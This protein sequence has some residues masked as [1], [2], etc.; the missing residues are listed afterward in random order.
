MINTD[1]GHVFQILWDFVLQVIK[2]MSTLWDFLTSKQTIGFNIPRVDVPVVGS[3][4]NW[5]IDFLNDWSL[6]FVPI[7]V[8]VGGGLITLLTLYLIKTFVPLA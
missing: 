5:F 8:F 7:Y 2:F 1:W 4:I 3:L 6:T